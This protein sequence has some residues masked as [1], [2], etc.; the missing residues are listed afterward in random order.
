[1]LLLRGNHGQFRTGKT[2]SGGLP[3][4]ISA[5]PAIAAYSVRKV[6]TGY[7]GPCVRVR[8]GSDNAE[9]DIGFTSTGDLDEVA[10][11]AFTGGEN[12]YFRSEEFDVGASWPLTN[13]TCTPNATTSPL[14]TV[15]ADLIVENASANVVHGVYGS[16]SLNPTVGV[17]YTASVYSKY[18]GRNLQLTFDSS[19]FGSTQYVNFDLQNGLVS[20]QVGGATGA[21][22]NVGDGWYRCSITATATGAS[23]A[24][25]AKVS[26]V[27][28]TTPSAVRAETYTG[29]G[30]SGFYLWGAQLNIGSI[31]PYQSTAGSIA[32]TG[33]GFVT[34]WYDQSTTGRHAIQ[35]TAANQPRIVEFGATNRLNNK[36]AIRVISGSQ[37][38][39]SFTS[40]TGNVDWTSYS[41]MGRAIAGDDLLIIGTTN[42]T[43]PFTS[44]FYRNGRI[45]VG[46][47]NSFLE[48]T[49]T[50]TG[51]RLMSAFSSGNTN[52]SMYMNGIQKTGTVTTQPSA[53]NFSTIGRRGSEY[54]T[55]LIQEGLFYPSGSTDQ[56]VAIESNINSYYTIY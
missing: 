44:Y 16:G 9:Q 55:G 41:V 49:D 24:N 54:S 3:L 8:R 19:G 15:T 43:L 47:P 48:I 14:G 5:T 46:N 22:S 42:A 23:G 12:Y 7:S 10:L 39:L 34:T 17:V 18:A 53:G 36:P 25:A 51:Q 32:S 13:F 50:T 38:S 37:L 56:R 1:M 35:A 28:I 52:L 4:D 21:I 2:S 33:S 30:T 20:L 29:N 40:I 27:S 31:R 11:V 45:Y 26:F 6:R